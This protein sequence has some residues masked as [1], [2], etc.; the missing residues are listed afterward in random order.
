MYSMTMSLIIKKNQGFN[1]TMFNVT[2]ALDWVMARRTEEKQ[3]GSEIYYQCIYFFFIRNE[4]IIMNDNLYT[5]I[6]IIICFY[7]S[8]ESHT[9]T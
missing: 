1:I 4:N 3:R 6:N 8:N 2:P 7:V 9:Q 5:L